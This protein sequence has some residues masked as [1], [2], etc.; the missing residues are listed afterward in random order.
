MQYQFLQ[1]SQGVCVHGKGNKTYYY[2]TF[3]QKN[4]SYWKNY[5]YICMLY[6]IINWKYVLVF[7]YIYYPHD[8]YSSGSRQPHWRTDRPLPPQKTYVC[9]K[10]RNQTPSMTTFLGLHVGRILIQHWYVKYI[11]RTTT[12]TKYIPYFS[13]FPSFL[14]PPYPPPHPPMTPP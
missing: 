1:G 4:D 10:L 9:A 2:S 5:I 12:L 14:P 7:I 6:I 11:L 13:Y 8:Y 3:P